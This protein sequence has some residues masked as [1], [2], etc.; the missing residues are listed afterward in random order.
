MSFEI[1]ENVD[2]VRNVSCQGG[3]PIEE[4]GRL[5][6]RYRKKADCVNPSPRGVGIYSA[7]SQT[8][9]DCSLCHANVL[10]IYVLPLRR[11]NMSLVTE[12]GHALRNFI[13]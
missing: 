1:E 12:D 5:C 2:V 13:I 4:H 6:P 11:Y 8:M 3:N 9:R 10:P 7:G